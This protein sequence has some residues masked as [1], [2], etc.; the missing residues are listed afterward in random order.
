MNKR[1]RNMSRKFS[2]F[3]SHIFLKMAKTCSENRLKPLGNSGQHCRSSILEGEESWLKALLDPC[4]LWPSFLRL[5]RLHGHYRRHNHLKVI[6]NFSNTTVRIIV[7][8]TA[9]CVKSG[10]GL[11]SI[12]S[13]LSGRTVKENIHSQVF[14]LRLPIDHIVIKQQNQLIV[15]I[16]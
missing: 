14:F 8:L 9:D 12:C 11:W 7:K 13:F 6:L 10:L 4:Q 2:W 1:V 5:Y 16:W 3:W 15:K